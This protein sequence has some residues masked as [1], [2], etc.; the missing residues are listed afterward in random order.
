MDFWSGWKNYIKEAENLRVLKNLIKF[1]KS[2]T[3][4]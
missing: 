3:H 4:I 1:Q 2:A